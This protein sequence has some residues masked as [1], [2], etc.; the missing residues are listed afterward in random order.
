MPVETDPFDLDIISVIEGT[1]KSSAI[2]HS[3]DYLRHYQRLL[4]RWRDE[5]INLVE[6]GVQGGFS[7]KVW[8]AYFTRAT[9]V[10]RPAESRVVTSFSAGGARSLT[11]AL[12]MYPPGSD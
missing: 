9:I 7:L 4:E 1:D 5:P 3:W 8:Q 10:G 11:Q 2:S 6:I 12:R